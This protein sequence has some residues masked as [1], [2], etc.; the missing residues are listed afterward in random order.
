MFEEED[1]RL[2]GLLHPIRRCPEDILRHIF[3]YVAHDEEDQLFKVATTLSHVCR[4]WRAITLSIHNLW[5]QIEV[6]ME[7]DDIEDLRSFMKRI[8]ERVG[9]TPVNVTIRDVISSLGSEADFMEC[10]DLQYFTTIITLVYQLTS[11]LDV[12]ELQGPPFFNQ[13][14]NV[15]GFIIIVQ[16]SAGLVTEWDLSRV[17]GPSPKLEL[18]QLEELGIVTFEAL[19][20]LPSL[21]RLYIFNM[22]AFHLPPFLAQHSRLQELVIEGDQFDMEPFAQDI[23]LPGVVLMAIKLVNGFPWDRISAP[24]LRQVEMDD[25]SDNA[26]AFLC[27]HPSIHILRYLILI[28]ELGFKELA[29]SMVNLRT[30]FIAGSTDGLFMEIDPDIPFP[31]FPKLRKLM[32]DQLD[33]ANISL[34]KFEQLLK[35]RCLPRDPSDTNNTERILSLGISLPTIEL[36]SVRWRRSALLAHI[37]QTIDKWG[38]SEVNCTVNLKFPN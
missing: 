38:E 36:N 37:P 28:S 17:L 22:K 2:A 1:D 20:T 12:Q 32:L 8:K 7:T 34:E 24:L 31:P 13:T 3:E 16:D 19:T 35:I 25:D 6:S 9:T 21:R 14:A 15:K 33:T 26:R 30:L 29:K 5:T 10:M 23:V 4:R 11:S 27:R 18:I